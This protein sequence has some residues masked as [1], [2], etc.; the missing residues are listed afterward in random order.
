[1]FKSQNSQRK[2]DY[3]RSDTRLFEE[4]SSAIVEKLSKIASNNSNLQP[5]GALLNM[6]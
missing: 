1:M 5:D 4:N 3:C 2:F 6:L